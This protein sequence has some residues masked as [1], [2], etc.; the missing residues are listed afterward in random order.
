MKYIYLVILWALLASCGAANTQSS[1]VE[2]LDTNYE[3][4][5]QKELAKDS[6]TTGSSSY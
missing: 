2:A 6:Q 4:T 5:Q 1:K 3:N